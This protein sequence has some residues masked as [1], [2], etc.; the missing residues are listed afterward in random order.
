MIFEILQ[1]ITEELND[2][3]DEKAVDLSNIAM[4]EGDGNSPANNPDISLTLINTQE[5]F[6]LKNTSNN[7]V[8]GTTVSYRNPKVYLNLYVLFSVDKSSYAES[9]K[10]L[11]KILAFFQGKKVFT[12]QNTNFEGIDGLGDLKTF[13]FITQLYT[14]SFEELNYIWGTLGGKQYP[15]VLYKITLLEIE[16]DIVTKEGT[17]VSGIEQQSIIKN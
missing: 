2:Y 16:R 8:E 13:K 11:T 12:H 4:A 1:I 6:A 5:E 3:F 7:R 10:S 15:S 17:V 9:L 14:P